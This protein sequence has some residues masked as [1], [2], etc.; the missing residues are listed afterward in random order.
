MG[1]NNIES[2][3]LEISKKKDK[4]FDSVNKVKNYMI[5]NGFSE[6]IN[7][8]FTKNEAGKSISIDNPL[9]SNRNYLRTSLRDSLL[10]NLLYNERRQK[11][12]I[13]FFEISDLYTKK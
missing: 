1:Y 2:K 5:K 7:F 11:D 13:K 3:P 8:P 6:V 4:I 12:S 10:E 9:D